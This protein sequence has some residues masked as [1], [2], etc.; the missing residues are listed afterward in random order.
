MTDCQFPIIHYEDPNQFQK[1]G[2][3]HGEHFRD[4][5]NELFQIRRKL[6]LEKNYSLK[7]KLKELALIQFQ[8]SKRYSPDISNE[9]EGISRGAKLNIDEIVLLNNYTD[10]RD[11]LL[12]DEGCSTIQS[13][14]REDSICGQTWDMHRSAKKYVSVIKIDGNENTSAQLIFSLVGCVGMMGFNANNL[15]IGVNNL[16][17]MNAKASLIWPVLIRNSLLSTSYQQ[18]EQVINEA[19]VTSGH[20]YQIS[21]STQGAQWEVTPVV[22]EKVYEIS[23]NNPTIFHTNH[24][25]GE[26]T[27][28]QEDTISSNSTTKIRFETLKKYQ[29]KTLDFEQAHKLLTGHEGYPKSIC[30]HFE[31]NTQD[32][33]TTCGGSLG[34][35]KHNKFKFWRGCQE[36]DQNYIAYNFKL[37]EDKRSF[38]L[39]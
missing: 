29:D 17:T 7:N 32:P 23:K 21:S 2:E 38:N 19:P 8:E 1:N 12:P 6:L 9:L 25:L 18:L 26:K 10:F 4:Q 36:Y 34:S 11:I 30:S 37:G 24:C 31:S 20:N 13:I 3:N 16:N 39:V 28:T 27:K 14:S 22:K 33:S 15:M 5:I 35:F